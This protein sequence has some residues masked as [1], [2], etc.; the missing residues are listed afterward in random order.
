MSDPTPPEGTPPDDPVVV[1]DDLSELDDL[2]PAEGEEVTGAGPGSVEELLELVETLTAERDRYLDAWQRTQ[3][4]FENAR[5]R[6]KREADE[7]ARLATGRVAEDLLPVLDACDAAVGH[8]EE[9]VAPVLA[10]L[11]Q[12]LEKHGLERI[13]PRGDVFDPNRHEAVMHEVAGPDDDP[14]LSVVTDV[15][16]IGYAWDGRVLRAAMVMVKG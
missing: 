6:L 14:A 16:R 1:P 8:G 7:A 13:D 11:L 15:F 12:T 5:R 2:P 10:A 3:A 4:D 9:G